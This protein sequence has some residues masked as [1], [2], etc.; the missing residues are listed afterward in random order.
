MNPFSRSILSVTTVAALLAGTLAAN[1]GADTLQVPAA[2]LAASDVVFAQAYAN[3]D[4]P[5][6]AGYH[7][8][9]FFASLDGTSLHADVLL[10]AAPDEAPEGGWPVIVS[11]GPYYNKGG[12]PTGPSP[13][14]TGPVERFADFVVGAD[15]FANGYAWVQVDSRGFGASGG[16]NDFGGIGEQMDAAAAVE[17]FAVQPWANGRAGMWGKSYDAF[18]QVMALAM[19]PPHLKATVIQSPLI[20][21][22]RGLWENGVHMAATWHITPGLYQAYDATPPSPLASGPEAFVNYAESTLRMPECYAEGQ[23]IAA[24]GYDHDLAYWQERDL[25]ARAKDSPVPVLWTH[26]FNDVNTQPN[27]I[28]DVY[29]HLPNARAWFGHW[30]HKRGNEQEHVGRD[31]FLE[32][33]LDFFDGHLKDNVDFALEVNRDNTVR[34]QTQFGDW[35]ASSQWPPADVVDVVLPLVEGSYVDTNGARDDVD[36]LWTFTEEFPHSAHLAGAPTFAVQASSPVPLANLIVKVYD[37]GPDGKGSQISRGAHLLEQDA[38]IGQPE[39]LTFDSFPI[40]WV[41][42][43]GHRI[44]VVLTSSDAQFFAKNT[45]STVTVTSSFVELPFKTTNVTYDDGIF[46]PASSVAP[47]SGVPT[48]QFSTNT[49]AWVF[50]PATN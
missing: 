31:G 26:G 42:E 10:P 7:Q 37:I 23:A 5:M 1:T 9:V 6:G 48:G 17:H 34:A 14:N 4:G 3:G 41:I 29:E 35:Y 21:T 36:G 22:Y 46:D 15:I 24:A 20:E 32:E 47:S 40:D 13:T 50:P 45:E 16:C 30:D 27:N 11:V 25:I 2:T 49:V 12:A 19:N 39:F 38:T 8:E 43:E 33:A 44:G 28:L 18:T